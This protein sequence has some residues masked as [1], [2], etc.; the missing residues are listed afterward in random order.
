L[1]SFVCR[2]PDDGLVET[3][4]FIDGA[5]FCS[6]HYIISSRYG[7]RRCV[8]GLEF[9]NKKQKWEGQQNR[10]RSFTTE[11]NFRSRRVSLLPKRDSTEQIY[12]VGDDVEW[13]QT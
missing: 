1:Y 5:I 11:I 3:E 12:R 4:T 10:T 13:Q 8:N 2:L 9:L 6:K 7:L